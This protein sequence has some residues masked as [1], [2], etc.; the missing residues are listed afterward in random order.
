[1]LIPL[2]FFNVAAGFEFNIQPPLLSST[3]NNDSSTH[4]YIIEK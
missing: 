1:M 4:F 3:K 2:S